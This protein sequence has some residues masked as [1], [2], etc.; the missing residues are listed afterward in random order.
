MLKVSI[1]DDIELMRRSIAQRL[2]A[3]PD[4]QVVGIFADGE[5][6]L[7]HLNY[8]DSSTFPDVILMDIEMPTN[9]IYTTG[10]VRSK[11]PTIEVV[12]LTIFDDDMTVY[13]AIKAGAM[14][15]LLKEESAETIARSI[16]DIKNGGSII[17]PSIARKIIR[18]LATMGTPPN[19]HVENN[20]LSKREI[21]ILELVS[22]GSTNPQIAEKLFISYETVRTHIRNIYEKLQVTNRTMAAR[23]A[24]DNRWIKG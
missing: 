16:L 20:P 12:M 2:S 9:G 14:G 6:L 23:K 10:I 24:A 4:I 13:D 17:S 3:I 8:C 18:F 11:Y 21:E 7:D 1:V 22:G 19:A 15:Y 5:F